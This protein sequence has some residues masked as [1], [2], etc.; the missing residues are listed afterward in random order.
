MRI[1]LG[2]EY[3]G[4]H[5]CGW[6]S[7]PGGCGVQDALERALQVLAGHDV[8]VTAAG[9][10][11]TGVHALSQVVHFD[12]DTERPMTAWVRG[13]NAHM[14][15]WVRVL[16]AQHV[17][18]RFNARFDAHSR[19]YQYILVNQAVA[20]AVLAGKVGW[21][22]LPLDVH[23]MQQAAEQLLGE[24]DFSAF[25][26][27]ECQAKS[28]V[29]TLTEASL[30]R[31]GNSITFSFSAN[32]FL[33]HQVR[34]MVGMLV[35]VGKGKLQANAVQMLLSERDRRLSPP[36]FAPDGLYLAGVGYDAHWGLPCTT[37]SVNLSL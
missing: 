1:A 5:F 4:S 34:N 32:A 35:Y 15:G 9:R 29:R 28:P 8:R 2:V 13:V 17:D 22:H 23:A 30:A 19:R 37:R 33:H 7:Q 3:D 36:T 12:T 11:D 27:A 21:F 26:A 16:W 6:Q 24:H 20:P 18:A 25:R 31:Q 10:T 14:P